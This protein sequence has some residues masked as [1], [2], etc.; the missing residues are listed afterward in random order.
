[1][2]DCR[3]Q[4]TRKFLLSSQ[5]QGNMNL[6]EEG[7]DVW[8]SFGFRL[9]C[10]DPGAQAGPGRWNISLFVSGSGTERLT[11]EAFVV[12]IKVI[13]FSSVGI[14]QTEMEFLLEPIL[15]VIISMAN[16][17]LIFVCVGFISRGSRCFFTSLGVMSHNTMVL[18]SA[19]LW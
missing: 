15:F 4:I 11:S 2:N 3:L 7:K 13:F 19:Q 10:T 12:A 17:Q 6:T 1:M 5:V 9:T 16:I 8:N 18:A 14:K